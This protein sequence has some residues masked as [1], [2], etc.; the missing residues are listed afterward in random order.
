MKIPNLKGLASVGKTF[1]M[2]NRPEILLASSL[3]SSIGGAIL[4][5]TG[6][7]KA[8]GIVDDARMKRVAS[9]EPPFDT[10]LEYKEEFV[11]NAPDLDVKEK[12]QLTW[13]CYM[14]AA[15]AVTTSVGSIGGL[16]LVHVKEKKALAT[17]AMAA[18][19]EIKKE[20]K[21]FEKE[22]LG[23]L[24]NDEKEK[25]LEDRAD[26]T[27]VGEDGHS[28]IQNSD[29]EVEELYLIRE[30]VTGRDIW[31]NKT[32][33]EEAIVEV[34]NMI[35]GSESASLNNFYDQA[36]YGRLETAELLGWSGVLPSISWHD[37][38][39]Q[40]ISGVRDDGR[41]WRG[42]RYTP[43]PEKGFDDPHR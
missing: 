16:H 43:S 30:P 12:I 18:I 1:F 28:H 42:F 24:S 17:A 21:E 9:P 20:A 23:V 22:N 35:N 27:P 11:K 25:I 39:G 5:A 8:R 38:N 41:P 37:E 14:P 7:Y 19:E 3:V 15:L 6:G 36:G 26:K 10:F 13:L 32:R 33:I 34:G 31:S 2:A 4:G 29:G 40:A